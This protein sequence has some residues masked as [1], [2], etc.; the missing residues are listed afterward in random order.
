MRKNSSQKKEQIF[1]LTEFK[2]LKE[3]TK[4]YLNKT[5]NELQSKKLEEL[6]DKVASGNDQFSLIPQI[7]D[8]LVSIYYLNYQTNDIDRLLS[9]HENKYTF[10]GTTWVN[11]ALAY[12]HDYLSYGETFFREQCL[13]YIERSL[14][15]VPGYG[16]ALALKLYVYMK[17]LEQALN[18]EEKKIALEKCHIQLKNILK[19][20][21]ISAFETLKRMNKDEK[22]WAKYIDLL[23]E[24]FPSELAEMKKIAEEYGL[25]NANKIP[26]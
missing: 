24:N 18:D 8:E 20:P 5:H 15:V 19:S 7:I 1:H 3:N 6:L 10:S 12:V 25:D 2:A 9:E 23:Y 4:G 14:I 26:N 17:D 16:E 11:G 22:I 13:K 21:N